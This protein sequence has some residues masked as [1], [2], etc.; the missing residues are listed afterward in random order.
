MFIHSSSIKLCKKPTPNVGLSPT[1]PFLCRR[2]R[3]APM[4]NKLPDH[5]MFIGFKIKNNKY[6]SLLMVMIEFYSS[7]KVGKPSSPREL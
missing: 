7:T 1:Y 2:D 6:I 3:V 4:K 5:G